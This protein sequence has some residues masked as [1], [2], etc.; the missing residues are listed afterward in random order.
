[1][2]QTML[3]ELTHENPAGKNYF[4][5]TLGLPATEHE[6]RDAYQRARITGTEDSYQDIT[7]LPS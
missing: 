7:V 2:K 5:A 3:I 6:I 1:M 4:H